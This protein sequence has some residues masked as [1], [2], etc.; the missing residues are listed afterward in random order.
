MQ[1]VLRT[2]ETA[3]SKCHVEI[4]TLL[5]NGMNDSEKEINEIAAYLSSLDKDIPP[6]FKVLSIV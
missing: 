3:Q 6:S 4:T 5:V 2:I 1:P